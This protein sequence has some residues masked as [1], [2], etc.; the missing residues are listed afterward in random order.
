LAEGEEEI[1]FEHALSLRIQQKSSQ[2]STYFF[3]S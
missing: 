1:V 3:T 2:K